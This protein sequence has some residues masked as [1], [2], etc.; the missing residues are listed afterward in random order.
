MKA[1]GF[2]LIELLISLV[3]LALLALAA[4]RGLDAVMQTRTQVSAETR[5][6]QQLAMFF[7]RLEQDIAQAVHRSVRDEGGVV[8]PEWVGHAVVV[9]DNDASLIFTRAGIADADAGQLAPQR[10]GY[11]LEH[12]RIVLLRW[13]A[14]DQ[15]QR[16]N[17]TRHA[18]LEGVRS[19]TWRYLARDGLW[20][21]QW[22]PV[23][24]VGMLPNAA[25]VELELLDGTSMTRVFALQ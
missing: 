14:L 10:I 19:F 5:K 2:T 16:A 25:E 9:G 22:P 1:R 11:R 4:Y 20:H 24:G 8:Q 17:P 21:T 12:D 7:S 3:I 13:A 15:P 18:V 23:A 6:W